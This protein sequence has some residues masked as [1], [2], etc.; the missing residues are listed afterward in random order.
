MAIAMAE[1]AHELGGDTVIPASVLAQVWRGGP[2]SARLAKLI[3]GSDID[4]LGEDRAREVGIRLGARKASDVP[5]AHV[6]CCA[7]ERRA[8]IATSDRD[9]IEALVEPNEAIRLIAI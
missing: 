8:V 3:S 5:D 9:D 4:A 6:V 1:Q 7:V 2:K